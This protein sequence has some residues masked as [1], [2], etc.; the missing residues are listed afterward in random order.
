M[1]SSL[2]CTALRFS[3][4]RQM[5]LTCSGSDMFKPRSKHSLLLKPL[6][7]ISQSCFS[8]PYNSKFSSDWQLWPF[9]L[10]EYIKCVKKF[11]RAELEEV[12]FKTAAEVARQLINSWVEKETDGKDWKMGSTYFPPPTINYILVLPHN[13]WKRWDKQAHRYE[14]ET[15]QS[16]NPHPHPHPNITEICAHQRSCILPPSALSLS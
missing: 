13:L 16:R 3:Y 2:S 8:H 5:W 14:N 7:C 11:Y 9:C 1:W 4:R 12:D 6:C 10:Q 15:P